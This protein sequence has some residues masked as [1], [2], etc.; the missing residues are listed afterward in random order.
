MS[1]AAHPQSLQSD[2][3][4]GPLSGIRVVDLTINVLGPVATQ[5]LGDMGADVI[6]VE[7]P[8]GDQNRQTGVREH[9]DMGALYLTM[10]RNKRSI[11]L[12]LK[13]PPAREALM[14]LVDTADVFVHSMRPQ[15]VEKLGV[16]YADISQRN[17]RVVYGYAPG[18]RSDG[19]RRNRPAFDDVIQGESGIVDMNHQAMGEPRYLPTIIADKLCGHILAS[20]VGMALFHRERTGEGQEIQVPMFENMVAFNLIE[21]MWMG[22][23]E[24]PKGDFGYVRLLN[25]QRRPY[26]TKDGHICMMASSD[27][28]WRRLLGA[29]GRPEVARDERYAK[30]EQRSRRFGE[31]YAIVAEEIRMRTTGE[32]RA[33][34]DAVDIPNGPVNRLADLQNDPYLVETGFF[35]HFEHPTEG[36]MI[37]TSIPVG[38]SRT[39]GNL[40]RPPPNLGEHTRSVLEELG[41]GEKEIVAVTG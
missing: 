35:K 28:Q 39:P 12:N 32:A 38:F 17:P 29:L 27:E 34:L 37:T 7:S 30:L 22:A 14:R 40:R 5:I 21:H 36:P 10:N 3:P 19:P 25:S 6:K 33:L 41:Y 8:E 1:Q 26:A 31:L 23:F 11:V 2:G 24:A 9:A 16:A 15:A 18:Y 4:T 13:K 20:S